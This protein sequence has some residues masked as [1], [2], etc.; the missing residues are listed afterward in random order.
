MKGEAAN[1]VAEGIPG[2]GESNVLGWFIRSAAMVLIVTGAAKVW[3]AFGDVKLL[4]VADPI[5]GIS[6]KHLMLAVGVV[7]IAVALVCSFNNRQTLAFGLVAWISTN[8]VVYRLG[9]W[10]MN[11][12]RPCGCLGN[13]TDA[14]NISPQAADNIMKL[15]LAYLFIGSYGFLFWEWRQKRRTIEARANT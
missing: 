1:N 8:F 5:V 15:V 7:E 11:W 12:K 3:T 9:L 14:L 10:W 13:L 2:F 4:T 6:F